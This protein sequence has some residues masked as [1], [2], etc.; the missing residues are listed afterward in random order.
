MEGFRQYKNHQPKMLIFC[1][2]F[3]LTVAKL[4]CKD[5]FFVPAVANWCRELHWW[6]YN[7][8]TRFYFL[9]MTTA[10]FN[11]ES[12]GIIQFLF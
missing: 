12:V 3:V 10:S 11:T 5:C 6:N 4:S 7:N 8:G 9:L 1:H 2:D